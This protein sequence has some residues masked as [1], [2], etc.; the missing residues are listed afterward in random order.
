MD[1][2]ESSTSGRPSLISIQAYRLEICISACAVYT[3]RNWTP[4]YPELGVEEEKLTINGH[5]CLKSVASRSMKRSST[6]GVSQHARL[7]ISDNGKHLFSDT[8][9]RHPKWSLWAE[10]GLFHGHHR[11]DSGPGRHAPT[12]AA[13]AASVVSGV[14]SIAATPT[15][16]V[17]MTYQAGARGSPVTPMS[18]VTTS[19]VV[20]PNT[21][22]T[23]A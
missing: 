1:G 11:P 23:K 12:Y 18:Q 22:T 21:V 13:S 19:C 16:L 10:S 7:A 6:S 15:T 17:A 2:Y 14:A 4:T 5:E 9:S 8:Q 3:H 20:P